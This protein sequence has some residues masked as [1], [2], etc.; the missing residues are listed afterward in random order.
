MPYAP[1]A[2][3]GDPAGQIARRGPY[4]GSV[5]PAR[6]RALRTL[7]GRQTLGTELQ[8]LQAVADELAAYRTCDQVREQL[9]PWDRAADIVTIGLPPAIPWGTIEATLRATA[10]APAADP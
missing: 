10:P 1:T 7:T 6:L 9:E 3:G 4:R 5:R 8:V 2:G